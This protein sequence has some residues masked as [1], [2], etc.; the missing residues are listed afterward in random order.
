VPFFA[1]ALFAGIRPDWN[2]GEISKVRAAH[3]NLGTDTIHIEPEVSKVNE[4]RNIVI[5]P[6]LKK[7]MQAYPIEDHPIIPFRNIECALIEVRKKFQLGHD[8]L[9]H[10]F[11]SMLVGKFR[12][13]GDAALQAGNSEQVVRK[14]YLDVISKEDASAFWEIEPS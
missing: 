2:D 12:S 8:V 7:W 14:H 11:I 4:K 9:R 10:T 6:N 1:L 13:V 3:I 5:Q